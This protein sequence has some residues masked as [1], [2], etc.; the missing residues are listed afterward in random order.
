MRTCRRPAWS[1]TIPATASGASRS[2]T[3]APDTALA[4]GASR[5]SRAVSGLGVV[6]CGVFPFVDEMDRHVEGM[7][8]ELEYAL[9]ALVGELARGVVA[10]VDVDETALALELDRQ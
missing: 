1:T 10:A 8:G 3:R 7:L 4:H 6:R 2:A 5:P 9:E